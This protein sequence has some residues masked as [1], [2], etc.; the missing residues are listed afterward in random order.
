[1]KLKKILAVVILGSLIFNFSGCGGNSNTNSLKVDVSAS[2]EWAQKSLNSLMSGKYNEAIQYGEKAI[3]LDPKN[4]A[5]YNCLGAA[6][7]KTN[8]YDQ[9]LKYGQKAVDINPNN[10]EAWYLLGFIYSRKG[11][12]ET[13]LQCLEKA[14][15]LKPDNKQYRENR[16]YLRKHMQ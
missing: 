12:N 13:A 7:L 3:N 14:L 4:Y 10:D 16:D 11:D 2:R 6:Y 5:A 8:D 1:M 9:A 15:E